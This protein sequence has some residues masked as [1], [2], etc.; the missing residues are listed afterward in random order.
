MRGEGELYVT[1]RR[2]ILQNTIDDN[3][4][5]RAFD[6]RNHKIYGEKYIKDK[7]HTYFYGYVENYNAI[8]TNDQKFL[9]AF[10]VEE[11]N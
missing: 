10:G 2:V 3:Q 8:F 4:A 1:N 9:I 5:L 7:D 6:I 11:L